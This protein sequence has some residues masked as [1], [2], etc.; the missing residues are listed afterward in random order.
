M[1]LFNIEYFLGNPSLRLIDS[2]HKDELAQIADHI[3]IT[4]SKQLL[5]KELKALVVSKL[6][7]LRIIVLSV[8]SDPAVL[9]DGTL[10]EGAGSRKLEFDPRGVQAVSAVVG[11]YEQLK[12][13]FTLP[14]YDPLSIAST[15]SRDEAR[16]KVHLPRL[17]MEAQER[18][19]NRQL[20]LEID[21]DKVVRL[22]QLELKSQR[23]A[24]AP[25][26]SADAVGMSFSST[27]LPRS[28][29]DISKHIALVPTFRETEVDSYFGAFEP[30]LQ[31]PP[32][33]WPILVQCKIHGKAQEAVAALPVEDSLKYDAVKAAILRAYELVP[34][35]YRQKFKNHKKAQKQTY[36]EFAREKGSLF[37]KWST[38][39]RAN[40]FDSL[41]ELILLE[42][43]KKVCLTVLWCT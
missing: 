3:S 36:V 10:T 41:Q 8:Q 4:Y 28:T 24:H 30:P 25:S 7:E 13:P 27:S 23:E 19:Q 2:S 42:E 26:T 16:L 34:E 6:V 22:R 20:Q 43:F 39:C 18:A 37:D 12:T 33:V 15:G 11:E 14:R 5:K 9:E 1:L 38:T 29:V 35:A 31:W 17:Q 40:C 32:E 21:A